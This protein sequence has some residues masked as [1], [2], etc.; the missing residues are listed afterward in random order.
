MMTD[1]SMTKDQKKEEE[2]EKEERK[3]KYEDSFFIN[4]VFKKKNW[5]IL[6]KVEYAELEIDINACNNNMYYVILKKNKEV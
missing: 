5:W 3:K 6:N 1:W 2:W 4:E